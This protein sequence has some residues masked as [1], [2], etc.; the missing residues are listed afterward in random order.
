MHRLYVER[1]RSR[2]QT[3]DPA[4]E[5][6][7]RLS[8]WLRASNLALVHDVPNKLAVIGLRLAPAAADSAVDLSG[9]LDEHIA[10]LAEQ[11]HGRFTAERLTSGWTSGVTCTPARF[12]TPHLKRWTA[13]DREARR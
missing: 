9:A 2:K 1:H 10:L 8:P 13:L 5:P 6:W 11:E 12:M 4:L 3:D 7:D